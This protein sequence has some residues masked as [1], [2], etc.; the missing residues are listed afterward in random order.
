MSS[1]SQAIRIINVPTY[2]YILRNENRSIVFRQN[3]KRE[4]GLGLTFSPLTF[5]VAAADPATLEM[6]K[7]QFGVDID[8]V[9]SVTAADGEQV[10][11]LMP[12]DGEEMDAATAGS[13]AESFTYYQNVV[14]DLQRN[15]HKH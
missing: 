15:W 2:I 3:M 11:V 12:Q 6:L 14:F 7:E 10:Y 8:R 9:Q 1:P 5:I 4:R 13:F